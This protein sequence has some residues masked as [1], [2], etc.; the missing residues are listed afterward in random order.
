MVFVVRC[1][2]WYHLH[3]LKNVK[4][5]HGGVLILVKLG[6]YFW[7]INKIKKF[8]WRLLVMFGMKWHQRNS[9]SPDFEDSGI[10]QLPYIKLNS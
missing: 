6:C 4:N 8:L 3:N 5:T 1:A 9:S 7:K 2:I 10:L